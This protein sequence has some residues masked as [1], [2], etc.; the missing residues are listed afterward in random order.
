MRALAALFREIAGLFVEEGSL[1]LA[2]LVWLACA[3]L[4]VRFAPAP[5]DGAL[6]FLGLAALLI[7]NARRGARRR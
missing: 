1:A 4:L 3:A 6:L 2:T 5:W 7:E